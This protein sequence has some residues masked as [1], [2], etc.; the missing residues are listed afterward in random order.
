ML[1]RTSKNAVTNRDAGHVAGAV[2][3]VRH[4]AQGE[5]RVHERRDEQTDRELARFVAQDALHDARRELAHRELNDNHRDRQHERG[6]AHHRGSDGRKNR[7]GGVR[8]ADQARGK[9]SYSN[10]RSRAI[11]PKEMA[12]PASTHRTGTNQRLDRR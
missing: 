10:A 1:A 6:Q 4:L 12:A 11:V 9:A 2:T 3:V 7:R 5:D 8:A